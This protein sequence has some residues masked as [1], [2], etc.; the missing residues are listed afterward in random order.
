[1]T[2]ITGRPVTLGLPE[3]SANHRRPHL[4]LL[5]L[6]LRD[7]GPAR[8]AG[9]PAARALAVHLVTASARDQLTALDTLAHA[10][11]AVQAS[12]G[13]LADLTPPT[14]A[15]WSALGIPPRPSWHL[16]VPVMPPPAPVAAPAT[17][18][19][20]TALG[21]IMRWR[22]RVLNRAGLP[23]TATISARGLR[24]PVR[25]ASDG[26]FVLVV[27]ADAPPERLSVRCAVGTFDLVPGSDPDDLTLVIPFP[28]ET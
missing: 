4:H 23:L 11:E 27:P 21:S 6:E 22:G 25:T 20:R 10:A 3:T 12:H 17:A 16:L 2:R 7:G 8:A 24:Q 14:V 1:M 5:P 28:V 9:F 18:P 26:S 13:L 15:L 19:L